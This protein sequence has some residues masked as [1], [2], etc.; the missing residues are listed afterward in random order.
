[1]KQDRSTKSS[2][3]L[4]L[5]AV[6]AHKPL[7]GW[8]ILEAIRK[9]SHGMLDFPEGTVY[10]L[11]YRLEHLHVIKSRVTHVR[12]RERR[13]YELTKQGRAALAAA[14]ASWENEVKSVRLVLRGG[15]HA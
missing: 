10:P 6:L 14:E 2:I 4:V 7:H 3:E 11:L 13:I 1:M 5:L 12:G 9:R 15:H 8:G